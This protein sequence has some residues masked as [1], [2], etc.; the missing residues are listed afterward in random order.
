MRRR[1]LGLL[2]I[3]ACQP[4][5]EEPRPP[6]PVVTAAFDPT[7][8]PPVVPTPNDLALRGGG[9]T[10]NVPDLPTDSAA[11]RRLNAFLR[12]LDGFP[13]ASTASARFSA[14]LDPATVT[15]GGSV[16]VFDL[17]AQTL[18]DPMQVSA[19]LGPGGT[20][21]VITPSERWTP[22]HRFAVLLFGGDDP[23]A[24]RGADGTRVV[25]SPTF[26]F[27]RAPRPLVARC[28]DPLNPACVCPDPLAE[29]CH[30]IVVGLDDDRARAA[31]VERLMINPL[32]TQLFAVAPGMRQRENLVLAWTFTI[33]GRPEAV[34]DPVRGDLPFPNDLLIDQ[35]TG[36]VNL[37]IEP[38]DPSAALKM[39][40]N[41]LDGF[42][43]TAAATV[44]I[45]LPAGATIDPATLVPGQTV[46][47]VNLDPRPGAPQ[48]AFRAL[49]AETGAIV[50]QPTEALVPDQNRYA[51]VVLDAVRDQAGR[52]LVP[53]PTV[54]LATGEAPIVEGGRSTVA[55]LDDEQAARLEQ[56]R[57]AW[58]PLLAAL[59]ARGVPRDRVAMLATF[60]TQSIAR[61]LLALQA[62]PATARGTGLPTDTELIAVAG[63]ADLQARAAELPFPIDNLRAIVIGAFATEDVGDRTD[64]MIPFR[65]DPTMP[66][67]PQLDRF[68]V[69][70]PVTPQ[71]VT[72][73]FW[74][75]VPKLPASA[76]GAPVVIL[77]HGLNAWRGQLIGL[78]DA[79]A[80]RG[81]AAIAFDVGFH[82][83]RSACTE[84]AQCDGGCDL[85]TGRCGGGM[86]PMPAAEDPLACALLP[87]SSDPR[88]CRPMA[89]G[90]AFVDT[91]D[92]F[93]TRTNGQQY[94]V[95]AAQ[96]VRVLR[97][98]ENS[99]GLPAQLAALP[100]PLVLDPSRVAFLG[101]SLGAIA[102]TL[103][104]AASPVVGPAV[105][106]VGGGH[107]FDILATG[108]LRGLVDEYLG[109][110][111]VA[112]DTPAFQE[113][114]ATATW[115]LDPIDPFA[116]AQ[117]VRRRPL[118]MLAPK[119]VIVQRAGQDTVI[120]TPF[121]E[122][123]AVELL[124]AP[125]P[126]TFFPDATHA[127]FIS[128][129]PP[130]TAAAMRTQAVTFITT[131][132]TP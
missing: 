99:A 82:G 55:Q 65:R 14:P 4:P 95:D 74:L 50:V 88:D 17:T 80:A 122:T 34:L 123:L 26:F 28:E 78:A 58:Q 5:V 127:T 27:L 66:G 132:T 44:P 64:Q 86:L 8:S 41:Q 109:A 45:D 61:P 89:S 103:L 6:E 46:L 83:A 120:P 126:A 37:P 49:P 87:L 128:L 63:E 52:P 43:T 81:W 3:A 39:K 7:A 106:T 75:S 84:D 110:I 129:Q 22:G 130:A 94:V 104:L 18:L 30:S 29:G 1:L 51:I 107:L 125:D 32:L 56:L 36:R 101:Y 31:E 16:L 62:Y 20:Q 23:A 77:Q 131:I 118:P 24:L 13:A 60:T 113:L 92:L 85:M 69:V 57:L 116:V 119:A 117:F 19:V 68:S 115:V 12:T 105:L 73:R 102:G 72:V 112:R 35:A 98:A 90:A 70:P 79:F 71:P 10:L 11:Q 53:P 9:G 47:L 48:P 91:R 100:E 76:G 111:G 25:A 2:L 114:R 108:D 93:R 42:S 67:T 15:V 54:V 38:G 97:D 21:V 33:T 124:G 96:L 121:Q 59:A 40:L